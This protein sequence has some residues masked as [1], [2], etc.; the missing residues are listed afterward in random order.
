MRKL[1]QIMETWGCPLRRLAAFVLALTLVGE[2]ALRSVPTAAAAEPQIEQLKMWKWNRVYQQS[3]LP[4][5]SSYTQ[6]LL[7]Y[8]SG[9]RLYMLSGS[10]GSVNTDK[11]RLQFNG[12]TPPWD[13]MGGTLTNTFYTA[14]LPTDTWVYY[15]GLDYANG[16]SGT[17]GKM[18]RF[19]SSLC[20]NGLGYD[21]PYFST[22]DDL[23]WTIVTQ[24]SDPSRKDGTEDNISNGY[25]KIFQ[26]VAGAGDRFMH[27]YDTS[28]GTNKNT[29][30]DDSQFIM[31][32]GTQITYPALK[33]YTVESG[34]VQ[35]LAQGVYIPQGVT[36]TVE[37]DAILTISGNLYNSG[38]IVNR[39]TVVLE[40]NACIQPTQWDDGGGLGCDGG[41]LILMSGARLITGSGD[42]DADCGNGFLMKNNA[43]CVN[44]GAIV[45]TG[46]VSLDSGATVENREG[47]AILM[48]YQLTT[49]SKGLMHQYTEEAVKNPASYLDPLT[50]WRLPNDYNKDGIYYGKAVLKSNL[51]TREWTYIYFSGDDLNA[52]EQKVGVFVALMR[53][54]VSAVKLPDGYPRSL[55]LGKDVLID[56]RG[57]ILYNTDLFQSSTAVVRNTEGGTMTENQSMDNV[58]LIRENDYV[59]RNPN[60]GV[61]L[62]VPVLTNVEQD[63]AQTS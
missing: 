12:V 15:E 18:Y 5:N 4:A 41:D 39:G 14:S 40:K 42:W 11:K 3:D 21:E 24:D 57:T 54:Y 9:G 60:L 56:N 49:E 48:G 31:Y 26:N 55:S 51:D 29:G 45:S 8:Y 2:L 13:A 23:K 17:Y 25:V 16:Y 30:W 27:V 46:N 36:I 59:C 38:K 32:V 34:Q 20:P 58:R 52:Y 63:V 53:Q 37:E 62:E 7:F 47:G 33:D 1:K 22:D 50:P 35:H 44:Y 19:R 61:T 6:I 28:V 10:S 43:S